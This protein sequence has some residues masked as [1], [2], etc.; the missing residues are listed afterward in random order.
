MLLPGLPKQAPGLAGGR[1]G[2]CST[3]RVPGG[4]VYYEADSYARKEMEGNVSD[5]MELKT[6][7]RQR[8]SNKRVTLDSCTAA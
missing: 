1:E 2:R 7:R 4:G 5:L 3:V 6:L 8:G